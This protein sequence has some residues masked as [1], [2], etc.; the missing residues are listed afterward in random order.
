MK[1][2]QDPAL[3]D[4]ATLTQDNLRLK[5]SC[6]LDSGNGGCPWSRSDTFEI[7]NTFNSAINNHEFNN[8]LPLFYFCSCVSWWYFAVF[9]PFCSIPPKTEGQQRTEIPDEIF[10]EDLHI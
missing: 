2:R 3:P 7:S 6:L 8:I 9:L 1:E 4:E 5:I 10:F